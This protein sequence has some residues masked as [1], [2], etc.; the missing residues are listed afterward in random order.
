M[1]CSNSLPNISCVSGGLLKN[2]FMTAE[3]SSSFTTA[4]D[5]SE[6]PSTT[7]SRTYGVLGRDCV[8]RCGHRGVVTG[9]VVWVCT[10]PLHIPLISRSEL[11]CPQHQTQSQ[12]LSEVEEESLLPCDQTYVECLIRGKWIMCAHCEC[13][14][15]SPPSPYPPHLPPHTPLTPHVPLTIP[16]LFHSTH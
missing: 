7:S 16:S 5:S 3:S 2:I 6:I 12:S 11:L 13:P 1:A 9:H 15:P 14:L 8:G 10:L 4:E